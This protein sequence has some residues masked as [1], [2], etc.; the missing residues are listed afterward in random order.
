LGTRRFRHLNPRFL[1]VL[2]IIA[3]LSTAAYGFAASNTVGTTKAGDGTGTISGYNVTHVTYTLG[4]SDPMLISGVAFTTDAVA[5]SVKAQ[6]TASGSWYPCTNA[7]SDGMTWSCTA[8][9]GGATS[10]SAADALR[11]VAVQ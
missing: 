4:A 7:N 6:L 8:P 5:T 11:V 1:I 9:G 10:V 3:I 2:A